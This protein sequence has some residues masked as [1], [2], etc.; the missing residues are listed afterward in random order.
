MLKNKHILIGISGGIAAYKIAELVSRLKKAEAEIKVIMTENACEFIT[1]T[2]ISA[3][4]D[5]EVFTTEFPTRKIDHITL[6]DWADIFVIA[7]ATANTIAKIA[8]GMADNLLTTT[9]L[10]CTAKKLIVPAMNVNMYENKIVQNNLKTLQKYGFSIMPPDTGK[11]ACGYTGK[12]RLPQ[13]SEILHFIDGLL[14][15]EKKLKR[16]KILITAGATIEE[17]DPMRYITN[18]SSGKTGLALARAA[19]IMGAD[20]TLIAANIKENIPEY[21][22]TVKV[23]SAKEMYETVNAIYK[24]FDIIIMAA[25]VSDYTPKTHNNK[26]IKK[27]ADLKLS[28]KRTTDILFEL[29]KNK[30]GQKL[31]GFAAETDNL[32]EYA[33]E[34]IKKKNLDYIVANELSVA[35]KEKTNVW[36]IDKSGKKINFKGS[37]LDVAI[38][39]LENIK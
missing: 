35:G 30:T 39:I 31:I 1:P 37:K 4:T 15:I 25:A 34:K 27:S 8:H 13:P 12:G 18:Y 22:K 29:G 3:I 2:T 38:K 9:I 6:A 28:L 26:K 17:I 33:K 23:K 16:Q 21:I 7:P 36:L 11:L 19:Y 5:N 32:I 10:A 24:D 14:Q 20:I